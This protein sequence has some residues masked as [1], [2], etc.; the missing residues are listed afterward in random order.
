MQVNVIAGKPSDSRQRS[1]AKPIRQPRAPQKLATTSASYHRL[2][3]E[4]MGN[5]ATLAQVTRC[6]DT[7]PALSAVRRLP[8]H[9]AA[10]RYRNVTANL[11]RFSGSVLRWRTR[12]AMTVRKLS[13][14]KLQ[15]QMLEILVD[16][17][18]R[19]AKSVQ[20]R[21]PRASTWPCSGWGLPCRFRYP[22]PPVGSAPS[23]PP[24]T[25]RFR[26]RPRVRFRPP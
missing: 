21:K 14:R 11:G 24:L 22:H 8:C 5:N 7:V 2:L 1:R 16:G 25:P 12:V 20:R 23:A 9:I 3:V 17:S 26:L 19:R 10:G 6:S 15:D 4:L 13:F 18:S